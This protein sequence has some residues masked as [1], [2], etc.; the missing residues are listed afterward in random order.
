VDSPRQVALLTSVGLEVSETD[1]SIE[2]EVPG[3]RPDIKRDVDL[4][5][6]VARLNGFERLP[7]TLP[8]GV[9][10]SLDVTQQA[11]R[12]TRRVLATSG[13]FEAWTTS[14]QANA[15]LDALGLAHEHPA[16]NVVAL[17]NP[18]SEDERDLR[19]TLLPGLLRSVARNTAYRSRSTALFEI[20]RVY[21][22]VRETLPQEAVVLGGAAT[23]ERVSK[24][25]LGD[26]QP[27]DFYA[28]KGLIEILL[29]SLGIRDLHWEPT[30]G[31]PF[32]PTRA[33]TVSSGNNVFG[34]V[35]ELHPD[36]CA[37]FEVENGAVAFELSFAALLAAA[38]AEPQ[39]EDLPRFPSTF[40]DVAI[41]VDEG[42]PAARATE[43]IA[44]EGLPELTKV[45]LFDVYRGDQVGPGS[46]SLAFSLELRN[47]ERTMT[48]TEAL[49]VRDRIVAAL[50]ERFNARLRS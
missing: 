23:G 13:F 36:V 14:F 38:A 43:I 19:S 46:K 1:E 9:S 18:M 4:I 12:Q 5:E 30:E 20:A 16:R 10:G 28:L 39:I 24:T 32:H 7:S 27:W 50:Q 6:E 45:E 34:V 17:S 48:E 22:P 33:A 40:L 11:E 21:E 8:P 35:G 42:I 31:L 2:V 3:F 37:R 41:V 49:A 29:Q 25:W 26:P 44:S 15:D 47:A